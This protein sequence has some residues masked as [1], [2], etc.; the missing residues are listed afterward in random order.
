MLLSA[1]VLASLVCVTGCG[2]TA[3]PNVAP[4]RGQSA[5]DATLPPTLR[6]M[7]RFYPDLA[8]GRFLSVADFESPNQQ[9]SFR[10]VNR[11]GET[12][13]PKPQ[14]SIFRARNETGAGSLRFVVPSGDARLAFSAGDDLRASL[15][16]DWSHW[17]LLL[18]SLSGPDQPTRLELT[19]QSG[20][21]QPLRW[22][23]SYVLSPGWNTL[24]ID[25]AEIGARI[26]LADVRAIEWR[27]P[28]ATSSTE[29]FLDDLV[30][31]DNTVKLLTPADGATGLDVRRVGRRIVVAVD[32]RFALHFREG[33]IVQWN[34][35]TTANLTVPTGLGPWPVA[36]PVGGLSLSAQPPAY[37]DPEMFAGWGVSA[38]ANESVVECSPRRAV[39]EGR[40]RFRNLNGTI[41][42]RPETSAS[43]L[44]GHTWRYAIYPDGRVYVLTTSVAP[45]DESTPDGA[46]TFDGWPTPEVGY[47][48][49]LRGG[50]GFELAPPSGNTAPS[51]RSILM[52][53]RETGQADLLWAPF[54][55]DLA[56]APLTLTTA[57]ERRLAVLCGALPA[58]L[59]V[60]T[61]HLLCVWPWDLDS[62]NES[63][64]LASDY[65][66]PAT[67]L[68]SAGS[69]KTDCAGDLDHDGFNEAE[70]LYELAAE[71]GIARV[72]LMPGPRLR[73]H[74]LL[75]V[76]GVREQNCWVYAD[77]RIIEAHGRDASGDL[78]I[79]IP[80]VL[81]S[82]CLLEV[83]AQPPT[84][85]PPQA[86]SAQN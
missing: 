14:V 16:R 69:A 55:A 65:R 46:P 17:P 75:R 34:G 43:A 80:R 59:R 13:G 5:S 21:E 38:V 50:L 76:H 53:R 7:Q 81:T 86:A 41:A 72:R 36:L 62:P 28:D 30:L 9:Q 52:T 27:L 20:R 54:T 82:E 79:E 15:P 40:W 70:G 74:P 73:Y 35:E 64:A 25:T 77:G 31:A 83:I 45:T 11:A 8:S 1:I 39:I 78:L 24:R 47:A 32:G 56:S 6:R 60:Q 58:A 33:V 29:A 71:D 61:A 22:T 85:A 37:D 18:M 26:D 12:V 84:D 63:G 42:D 23:R 49:A 10:V 4:Q 19:V 66:H 48:V 3:G 57:D 68:F 2:D 67:L 51:D 44:V